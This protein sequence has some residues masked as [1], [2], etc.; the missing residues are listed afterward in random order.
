MRNRIRNLLTSL[1]TLALALLA[2]LV[3]VAAGPGSASA[4]KP[5]GG[6]YT[7]KT[8]NGG[9]FTF[10]LSGKKVSGIKGLLPTICLETAGSY[11]SRAGSELFR[12]PGT[13]VLGKNKKAKA[14][15]PAA[16]NQGIAATKNYEVLIKPSGS[17]LKG[18]V[19]LNYSFLTPGPDIYTSYIWICQSSVSLTAKKG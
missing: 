16:M 6:K 12:P 1:S 11:Q 4:A 19:K 14:K 18:K 13:F 17:K 2:I 5:A 7:A 10:K 15:Q 3:M 9:K 8:E